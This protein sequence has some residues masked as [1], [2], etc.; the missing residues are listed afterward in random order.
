[1]N[2]Q[3]HSTLF[4]KPKISEEELQIK[5]AQKNSDKFEVLYNKYYEQI[6]RYIYQRVSDKQVAFDLCSQVFLKA[7]INLKDYKY[8]GFPFSA[9]LYRIAKSETYQSFRDNKN[10]RIININDSQLEA[11]A[12][13]FNEKQNIGNKELIK[14]LSQL[15]EEEIQFIEMRFFEERSYREI[16]NILEIKENYAKVKTHRIIQKM[17]KLIQQ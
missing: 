4:E 2:K 17:K 10:H 11:I 7:M 5:E 12:E 6:F 8:Q 9:W 3:H 1:M 14:L 15:K 16:A 13:E